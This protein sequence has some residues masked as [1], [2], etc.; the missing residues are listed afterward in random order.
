MLISSIKIL[1]LSK[2]NVL[3]MVLINEVLPDPV[4]PIIPKELPASR[5]KLIF[6]S[7][8]AFLEF[9]EWSN[10][11]YTQIEYNKILERI[12]KTII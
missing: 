1:P 6:P 2:S 5:Q 9:S 8:G 12:N 11:K 3:N 4:D 7:I 10:F